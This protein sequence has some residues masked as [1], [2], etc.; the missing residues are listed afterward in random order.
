MNGSSWIIIKS[1]LSGQIE[2]NSSKAPDLCKTINVS[3]VVQLVWTREPIKRF[4]EL[5]LSPTATNNVVHRCLV[6]MES[7][8]LKHLA[9]WRLAI[10]GLFLVKTSIPTPL[11]FYFCLTLLRLELVVLQSHVEWGLVL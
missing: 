10:S 9:Q 3:E 1:I 5:R 7:R 4:S 2:Y 6:E 11:I 8:V